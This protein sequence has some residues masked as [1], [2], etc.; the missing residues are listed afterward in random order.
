[1]SQR[2]LRLTGVGVPITDAF[3]AVVEEI[4][5]NGPADFD[6]LS[7]RI[8]SAMYL[9]EK[10]ILSAGWRT[11]DDFARDIIDQISGVDSDAVP[12]LMK[13]QGK[14]TAI[15]F[16]K[17]V[18][19]AAIP[20]ADISYTV[21]DEETRHERDIDARDEMETVRLYADVQRHLETIR[22]PVALEYYK[23]AERALWRAKRVYK[24]H[25][26]VPEARD[27]EPDGTVHPAAP[28]KRTGLLEGTEEAY[29]QFAGRW[30]NATMVTAYWNVHHPDQDPL[31]NSSGAITRKLKADTENGRLTRRGTVGLYEYYVN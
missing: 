3:Q 24:G 28:K 19:Y 23:K 27:P 4:I 11:W 29:K 8:Q 20:K 12:T 22:N 14:W 6:T 26:D 13:I 17:G 15:E 9:K 2:V 21:W 7:K 5:D 31:P 18:S 25:E 16:T 1:M 10:K 30:F